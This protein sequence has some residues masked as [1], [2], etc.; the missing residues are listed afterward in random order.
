MNASEEPRIAGLYPDPTTDGNAGE[1]LVLSVP[2]PSVLAD[3]KWTI[4]DDHTTAALPNETEAGRVALSIDPDRAETMTA[5][6]VAELEGHLQLSADGDDPAPE[7]D[8][9]VVAVGAV[10]RYVPFGAPER[11]E[12]DRGTGSDREE[13]PGSGV[14]PPAEQPVGSDRSGDEGKRNEVGGK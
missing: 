1:F 11:R 14:G 3:H 9:E 8:S 5:R 6:P 2:D 13:D 4:T 12:I 7:R 10:R